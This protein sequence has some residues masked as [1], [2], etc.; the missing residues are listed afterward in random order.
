M[1]RVGAVLMALLIGGGCRA[2]APRLEITSGRHREWVQK[3]LDAHLTGIAPD[4]RGSV[5]FISTGAFYAGA[6]A[7]HPTRFTLSVGQA[8]DKPDDH[9]VTTLT[10]KRVG[11]AGIVLR[12]QHRFN[13]TDFG[14]NK[15]S[16]DE[17]AI[18]LPYKR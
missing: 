4:G 2:D 5:T 16:I 18:E 10:V 13:E 11:P 3:S 14:A 15:V 7:G 8:F 1:R 12:Y 17:G 6:A 9:G